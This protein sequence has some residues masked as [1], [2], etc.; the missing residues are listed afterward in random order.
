MSRISV[1]YGGG[2]DLSSTCFVSTTVDEDPSVGG[3]CDADDPVGTVTLA[4]PETFF[5]FLAPP[6]VG[7]GGRPGASLTHLT[8]AAARSVQIG[9]SLLSSS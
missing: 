1:V 2:P 4:L 9:Y 7:S 6:A 8:T 5:F 3:G